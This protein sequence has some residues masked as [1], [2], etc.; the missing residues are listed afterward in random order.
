MRQGNR[1]YFYAALDQHFPG[2]KE[3]YQKKYGLSYELQSP[4]HDELM[5]YCRAFCK[6]HHILFSTDEVFQFLHEF[7]VQTE[8][9]SLF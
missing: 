8:Q 4:H 1:E 3:I 2:L 7:P 5:D 9:L 6:K